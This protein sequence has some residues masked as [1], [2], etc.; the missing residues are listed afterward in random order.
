MS[1]M[2]EAMEERSGGQ[3]V[4]VDALIGMMDKNGNGVIELE[5]VTE[6]V[7]RMTTQPQQPQQQQ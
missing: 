7:H 3:K 2:A 6:M 4:D 5:E 1:G